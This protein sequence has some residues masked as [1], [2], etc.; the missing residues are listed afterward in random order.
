MSCAHRAGTFEQVSVVNCQE[1]FEL[2]LLTLARVRH[3]KLGYQA[4]G[5]LEHVEYFFGFDES[6][7]EHKILRMRGD[8]HSTPTIEMIVLS[9]SND[10]W[11]KVDASFDINPNIWP[12]DI[13]NNVCVN[14]VLHIMLR[15]TVENLPFDL[16][17]NM[18][19]IVKV[20]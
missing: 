15:R 19:S 1:Y 2:S 13:G 3:L 12:R 7:N 20:P 9:R 16:R 4:C 11:R 6:T 5:T 18:F 17:T 14:G 10:S 8:D